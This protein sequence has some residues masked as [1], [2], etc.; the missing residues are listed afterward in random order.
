M[1]MLP[2]RRTRF[3][4]KVRG[5]Q[6]L[7]ERRPPRP[8]G[9]RRNNGEQYLFKEPRNV[10]VPPDYQLLICFGETESILIDTDGIAEIIEN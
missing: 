4:K 10:G 1:C 7:I 3:T 2:R 9:V 5:I 6:N 8:F